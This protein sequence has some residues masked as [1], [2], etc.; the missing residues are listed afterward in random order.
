MDFYSVIM[1]FFWVSVILFAA[2][3]IREHVKVLQNFFIPASLI[4]G[5]IAWVLGP[6]GLKV[7]PITSLCGD[8]ANAFITILFATIGLQGLGIQKGEGKKRAKDIAGYCVYRQINWAVQF[9]VPM[10][11][12]ILLLSHFYTGGDLHPAFGWLIPT[13][14]IG[15]TGPAIAA[16]EVLAD[17][18]FTDFTGLG[19]TAAAF[20]MLLGL[21]GGIIMIK[22]AAKRGYTSYI[23]NTDTIS[24]ELLTGII[25]KGK[26]PSMGEETISSIALE[27]MAWHLALIMIPTGIAHVVTVKGSELLGFELPEFSV[28][29]FISLILYYVFQAT[30]VN[31]SVDPKVING[32]GNLI[33]DY[34]VVFSLAMVQV[35]VIIK[36]A[37]PFIS[38]ILIF[39][40]W[41][42][43]WFWFGGPHIIGKDWFERGLFNWGYATG[44]F[45]T[46]FCLLR[47]ADPDNRS[48][49][50]SDTAILTPFEHVVEITALTLG[51]V[52][53]A[54]GAEWTYLGVAVV[55]GLLWVASIF[56]LKLWK[57]RVYKISPTNPKY[58]P[59]QAA[60]YD[61]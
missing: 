42:I 29:F 28:A 1:D 22:M 41:V 53:L 25:P 3:I 48:T 47:V 30:K 2:K 20:G 8:Y 12:S 15:G 45:A 38:L 52:L 51:P 43:V 44:T 16:G 46:G 37:V 31:D 17:Y 60:K 61:G 4:A 14:F 32:F 39:T 9:S 55:Y 23:Q 26:R 27:P 19:V 56:F 11:I 40:A 18:G 50:L 6:Y 7:I 54:T 13:A 49:A 33:S 10:I 21:I 34:V 58:D 36:Y 59:A 5:F 24:P 57:R 35:D